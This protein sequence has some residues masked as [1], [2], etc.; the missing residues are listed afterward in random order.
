MRLGRRARRSREAAPIDVTSLIDAAFILIIFLVLT[1]TFRK[2]HQAFVVK[3]PTAAH[4]EV[5]VETERTSV[6]VRRD[7]TTYLLD[8]ATVTP[9]GPPPEAQPL[10]RS[11]LAE[12]LR[13]IA[14]TKPSEPLR[15]LAERDTPYQL[16]VQL[17]ALARKAGISDVQ[18][19]YDYA[20]PDAEQ[21]PSTP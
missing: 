21:A 12:R 6:Y 20:S 7:G 9:E 5:V 17:M 15:I 11:R 14:Q 16:I 4:E 2:R 19:V 13:A 18:L 8:L 1:T 3:L 10:S